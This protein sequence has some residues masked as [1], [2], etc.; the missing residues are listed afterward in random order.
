M[1]QIGNNGQAGSRGTDH[2]CDRRQGGVG[3]TTVGVNLAMIL[4]ERKKAGSVALVD[5]NS[6]LW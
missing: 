3:T 6:V 2:Q 4:A 5:L 1:Q